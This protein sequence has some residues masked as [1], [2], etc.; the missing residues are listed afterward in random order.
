MFAAL[1]LLQGSLLVS[2]LELGDKPPE[3]RAVAEAVFMAINQTGRTGKVL[4]ALA[5][6]APKLAGL[7]SWPVAPA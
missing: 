7:G 3:T 6:M 4:I 1:L 2:P 5:Q